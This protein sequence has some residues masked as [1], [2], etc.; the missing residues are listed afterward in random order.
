MNINILIEMIEN[1][2]IFE[3]YFKILLGGLYGIATIVITVMSIAANIINGKFLNMYANKLFR[4]NICF[5]FLPIYYLVAYT[6][7][8]MKWSFFSTNIIIILVFIVLFLVFI[9]YASYLTAQYVIDTKRFQVKVLEVSIKE[10]KKAIKNKDNSNSI[11]IQYIC[12]AYKSI[13]SSE[14]RIFVEN[15][16]REELYNRYIEQIDIDTISDKELIDLLE[17]LTT[18]FGKTKAFELC[19]GFN[20]GQLTYIY[21][22]GVNQSSSREMMKMCIEKIHSYITYCELIMDNKEYYFLIN[23]MNIRLMLKHT[24]YL[25]LTLKYINNQKF[26]IQDANYLVFIIKQI[27]KIS[28]M[29]DLYNLKMDEKEELLLKK[30]LDS[31]KDYKWEKT[32]NSNDEVIQTALIIIGG[33]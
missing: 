31:S 3:E 15:K 32:G 16:D 23:D 20:R 1:N 22:L 2:T 28:K 26:V 25:L 9:T 11:V 27:F 10:L 14:C 12:E 6:I 29:V 13:N 8:A 21:M 4:F 18:E 24:E 19:E 17:I 33:L 30:I 7:L 5:C